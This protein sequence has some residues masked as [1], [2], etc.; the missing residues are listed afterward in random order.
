DRIEEAPRGVR[1]R[2]VDA[3]RSAVVRQARDIGI[4]EEEIQGLT[5]VGDLMGAVGPHG[6]PN[7]VL[8]DTRP[9]LWA[10]GGEDR[11][12][13]HRSALRLAGVQRRFGLPGQGV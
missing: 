2:A 6:D 4:T 13:E 12:P 5:E 11:R 7:G 9:R 10:P 8:V 3:R 1:P